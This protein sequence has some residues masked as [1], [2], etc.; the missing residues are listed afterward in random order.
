MIYPFFSGSSRL[1]YDAKSLVNGRPSIYLND[2]VFMPGGTIIM[3]DSSPTFDYANEF[4]IRFEGRPDG[5][6]YFCI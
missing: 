4:W 6:Q 5:R 2:I 1:I 3:S